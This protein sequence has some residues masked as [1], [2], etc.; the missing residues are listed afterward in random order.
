MALALFGIAATLIAAALTVW[1]TLRAR[2]PPPADLDLVDVDVPD[3]ERTQ[4]HRW[5]WNPVPAAPEPFVVDLKVRNTGG[6]AAVITRARIDIDQALEWHRWVAPQ[7]VVYDTGFSVGAALRVSE[8]YQARLPAAWDAAGRRIDLPLSQVI[9]GG[10]ADRFQLHLRAEAAYDPQVYLL[11]I[12]LA[13]GAESIGIGPVVLAT[14][15][16]LPIVAP[17]RIEADLVEFFAD[18]EALSS[19]LA[20]LPRGADGEAP[21]EYASWKNGVLRA[22]GRRAVSRAFEQRPDQVVYVVTPEFANP[23]EA[24][25]TRLDRLEHQCRTLKRMIE[26]APVGHRGLT[27]MQPRLQETLAAL[28]RLRAAHLDPRKDPQPP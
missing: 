22:P 15:P 17:A 28:P 21:A 26:A 8:V 3:P 14:E 19:L 10:E 11:R 13:Y 1:A 18:V 5:E 12:A 25:Q 6:Q 4:L 27:W 7:A 2:R 23:L 16:F 9:T 24:V 20:G